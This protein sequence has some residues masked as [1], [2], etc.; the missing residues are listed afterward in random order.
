[1]FVERPEVAVSHTEDG[2]DR[3][4]RPRFEVD[5]VAT[6]LLVH[7]GSTLS[8]RVLDISLGGCRIRTNDRFIAGILVRVEV[9]FKVRG[10]A[11]RFSGVTQWTDGR[12]LVGVRFLDL[13]AR[14]F[15][16]LTE[17]LAEVE[18]AAEAKKLAA[19]AQ[20]L[21][22]ISEVLPL[23]TPS[24]EEQEPPPV[25]NFEQPES[26]LRALPHADNGI[27]ELRPV[28]MVAIGRIGAASSPV[29]ELRMVEAAPAAS[30]ARRPMN[31]DRRESS[32]QPV[33]SSA[34]VYLINVASTLSGRILDLSL[35]G[36]RIRTRERFP[37]GIYTRVE[38]E[39]RLEGLPFRLGGVIQA[40]H[41]RQTV[42]IRFLDMSPRKRE[43]LEQL[44]V[45]IGELSG[46][47]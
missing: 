39:F 11:F 19:Q 20:A 27:A 26:G 24:R 6:I 4:T 47:Q 30:I 25:P 42:G 15:E 32:R 1:M 31:R 33:D 2:P 40:I 23:S 17:A 22:V 44:I 45:E 5:E 12:C 37:V 18:A 10:I 36:C 8:C 43:Q 29:S 9:A 3:R 38:A 7:H 13:G 14:R 46:R 41:D 35:N 28:P 34:V 16:E 21:E